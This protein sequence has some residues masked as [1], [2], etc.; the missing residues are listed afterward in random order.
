[1]S[2][3]DAASDVVTSDGAASAD[4]ATTVLVTAATGTVGRH[5]V[6]ALL[7]RGV[8][9]RAGTRRPDSAD[10][11]ADATATAFDYERP[12]TW[13]SALDGA[14]GLFLVLPPGGAGVDRL[15][16][17]AAAAVRTGVERVV[18]LSTLGADKVPVLPHRRIERRLAGL[19]ATTTFLRASFFMQNLTE[20][21]GDEIRE[22]GALVVPAGD[23]RTSFVDAVARAAD[24]PRPGALDVT[25]PAAPTYHEVAAILSDVLDREVAY[26]A[27]SIPAFLRYSVPR[28][29][30]AFSVVMVGIYT[31]A[32]LGL[33]GRVTDTVRDVLGR[34]PRD[35]RTFVERERAALTG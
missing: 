25:G 27:P 13:G 34:E 32:R 28:R 5:L 33:A 7:D 8:A 6:D 14:D 29:G 9:V 3:A 30:L 26:D 24:E 11:P 12:E 15:A 1:M 19:A 21:H 18:F 31:S 16:E 17:F 22:D 10:L 23:G 2:G 4:G 35:L 20:V